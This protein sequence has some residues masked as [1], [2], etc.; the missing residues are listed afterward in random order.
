MVLRL[1]FGKLWGWVVAV[2]AIGAFLAGL[3]AKGRSDGKSTAYEK[4]RK[5][6]DAAI[7][8]KRAIEDDLA[9]DSDSELDERLS[10]WVTD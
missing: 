10:R 6:T 4:Q 9:N 8:E 7:K 3:Y 1:I 2:G 5:E